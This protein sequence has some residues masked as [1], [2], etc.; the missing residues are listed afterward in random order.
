MNNVNNNDDAV[1]HTSVF[2]PLAVSV[3]ADAALGTG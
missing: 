3:S 2:P 1:T